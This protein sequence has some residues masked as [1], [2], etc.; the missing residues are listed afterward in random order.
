VAALPSL[1]AACAGGGWDTQVPLASL[2]VHLDALDSEAKAS[3]VAQL[4]SA[5]REALA[6]L[7][8]FRGH[9]GLAGLAFELMERQNQTEIDVLEQVAAME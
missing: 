7:V 1:V 6:S 9:E 2:L 3:V 4:L 8:R 5:R